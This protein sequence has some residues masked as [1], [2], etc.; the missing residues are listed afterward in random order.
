MV[1]P[2]NSICLDYMLDG[3]SDL[4]VVGD[5]E[6]DEIDLGGYTE[7]FQFLDG[8]LTSVEIAAAENI[9]VGRMAQTSNLENGEA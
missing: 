4:V 1:L 2:S 3:R 6:L 5:I 8:L 9:G 7:T